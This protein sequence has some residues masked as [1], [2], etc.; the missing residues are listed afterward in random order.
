M[1]RAPTTSATDFLHAS[2]ICK[3]V[4][5]ELQSGNY[6]KV[7]FKGGSSFGKRFRCQMLSFLG[8]LSL[9]GYGP[10]QKIE[11]VEVC[12]FGMVKDYCSSLAIFEEIICQELQKIRSTS[13]SS[14]M[15]ESKEDHHK[16]SFESS[17]VMLP[18][19]PD[20]KDIRVVSWGALFLALGVLPVVSARPL[21]SSISFH[22]C[23]LLLAVLILKK[24]RCLLGGMHS[25][26]VLNHRE[27][28]QS[29]QIELGKNK[30]VV[31]HEDWTQRN[32]GDQHEKTLEIGENVQ[33]LKSLEVA[34]VVMFNASND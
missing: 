13:F 9:R 16:K 6:R 23:R 22:L 18:R 17:V 1:G 5:I 20:A 34:R 19:T 21:C 14:K 25:V 15:I 30:K 33:H 31:V 26:M 28:K 29:F 24:L 27:D 2:K 11:G 32:V 8:F 10:F 3:W 4:N 12:L 7:L